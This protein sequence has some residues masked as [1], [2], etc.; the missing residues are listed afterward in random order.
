MTYEN[1][2]KLR[3]DVFKIYLYLVFSL[4]P[5]VRTNKKTLV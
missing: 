4:T 1:A 3:M 5:F 2:E